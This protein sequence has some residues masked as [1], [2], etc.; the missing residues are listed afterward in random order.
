ITQARRDI[1]IA[2]AYFCPG[3]QFRRAL[4]K[5]AARGVRVRLLLDDNGTAGLDTVLAALDA[6]PNI[7]VRLYNPFVVRWPKSI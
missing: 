5:A 3:R 6:H 4:A 7:E 1:L 2:H